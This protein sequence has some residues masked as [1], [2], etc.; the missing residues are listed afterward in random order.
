MAAQVDISTLR[1]GIGRYW[2]DNWR[3]GSRKTPG[4]FLPACLVPL[5]L[6]PLAL[7]GVPVLKDG[8]G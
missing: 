2:I 7:A 3:V 1:M 8:P 6:G 4:P 5:M